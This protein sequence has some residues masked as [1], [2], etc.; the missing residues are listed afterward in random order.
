MVSLTQRKGATA[1]ACLMAF[2]FCLGVTAASAETHMMPKRQA[3]INVPVVVW[4]VTTHPNGTTT[5]TGDFG[6]GSATVTGPVVDRSYIAAPH[7]YTAPGTYTASLTID[8]AVGANE[9]ATVEIEVF[10]PAAL[11]PA[12][13]RGLGI[14]N[15]IQDGLRWLWTAQTSRTAVFPASATTSWGAFPRS[16]TSLVVLAFEN[17]G[18]RVPTD[19]SEPTGLYEKYVVQK[20]LNY[21]VSQLSQTPLTVQTLPAPDRNPCVGPGIEAAPCQGLYN[22]EQPGYGTAI[23]ALS[24]AGSGALG[25]HV[26]AGLGGT[27]GVFVTGKT[28][29][30]VLQRIMNAIAWGQNDVLSCIGRGGWIYGFSN[31]GCQQSDGSTVGWDILALLDAGAAGTTIPAFV[32]DEFEAFAYP[33]GF[34]TDGTFDYRA[35]GNPATAGGVGNNLAR[36]GIAMQAQ[37][38]IGKGVGDPQVV[39]SRNAISSRWSGLNPP[40]DYLD[41][42]GSNKQNKGCAYAMYNVFKALKIQG[43][44]SLAAAA[45]WYGEYEDW[46][47]AN[48]T[49]PTATTGGSWTGGVGKTAMTFSCCHNDNTANAAIAE[50]ILSPVALIPPDPGLFR[51]VGLSPA[52][53]TNP[54][55]TDHTVTATALSAAKAPIPGVTI[56]FE[57]LTGPN[58]G[59]TGSDTTDTDGKA[60][61]TY[62]DD[63]GVVGTDTIQASIDSA[64]GVLLS[65]IVEKHWVVAVTRCDAD[66]DGDVD[67]DDLRIIRAATRT[68]ASGPTDPRDGNGDGR[69]NAAD[70]RFCTLRCTRAAC[71]VEEEILTGPNIR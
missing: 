49:D 48:Q 37:H 6:D 34:N 43:I 44:T 25:R 1:V 18:Y 53:A 2:M 71:A 51:T 23:S 42:C 62:H 56:D 38:Y 52:T 68:D 20:G 24:L 19:D 5:F 32:K 3:L 31:N 12:D 70:V 54:V 63:A 50:L 55:G 22:S 57:V 11:T 26:V 40:G 16:Y 29:G 59:K 9:T 13:L 61:F 45:D 65:N 69:I 39:A 30:E 7:T 41:T 67:T 66:V 28:Y 58:A 36:S 27:S 33:Q 35:N 17:H 60:T 47:V 15:A 4:G 64:A 21:V 46:L 8:P 14:N 10:N